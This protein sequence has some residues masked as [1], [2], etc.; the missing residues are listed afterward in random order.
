MFAQAPPQTE[1]QTLGDIAEHALLLVVPFMQETVHSNPVVGLVVVV[2]AVAVVVVVV[3]M[4]VL[5]V[6][7]VVVVVA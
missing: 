5:V 1:L 3:A 6:V 7:E 2:V 4:V